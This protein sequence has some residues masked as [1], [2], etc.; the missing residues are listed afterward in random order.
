LYQELISWRRIDG[1]MPIDADRYEAPG[2][3]SQRFRAPAFQPFGFSRRFVG[4]CLQY[5]V[6]ISSELF[7]PL[8]P[9]P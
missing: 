8:R 6:F 1:D 2:P 5:G 3:T 7:Q 4:D 9:I